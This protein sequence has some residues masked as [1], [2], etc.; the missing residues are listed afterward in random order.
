SKIKDQGSKIKDHLR[1]AGKPSTVKSIIES[2]KAAEQEK[3]RKEQE[4]EMKRR[5]E[6]DRLRLRGAV[7]GGLVPLVPLVP[8]VSLVPL[9]IYILPGRGVPPPAPPP[10]PRVEPWA[11]PGTIFDLMF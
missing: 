1:K 3:K 4:D 6:E 9:F 11:E 7:G 5:L 10:A 8:L 2:Q